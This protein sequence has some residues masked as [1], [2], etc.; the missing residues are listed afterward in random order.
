MKN[1]EKILVVSFGTSYSGSR[2]LTIGAIEKAI[3]ERFPAYEV[4]RAFTS[5]VIIDLLREREGLKIDHVREGLRRA[6][7]DGAKTLVVQP[8]HMMNGY[9]Y[10]GLMAVLEEYR[11][12]FDSMVTGKPLLTDEED[13]D[14]VIKAITENTASCDDGETALCFM[15]HGTEAASNMV[16]EKL[17]RKLQD[18][19]YVNYYIGTVE[20][21]PSLEDIAKRLREEGRYKKVVLKPL[22]VVAGDHASHDMAG[23]DKSSWKSVLEREGYEVEC[24]LEG[25]GQIRAIRDIYGDH[26]QAALKGLNGS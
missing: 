11:N 4:R 17:Q 16:Y 20:A 7:E 5:Q 12:Q 22:M 2:E 21:K 3:G 14:K 15:G 25:L 18:K 10:M 26:V 23:D 1:D 9:E 24:I 6:R 8:T 13:F 19:G